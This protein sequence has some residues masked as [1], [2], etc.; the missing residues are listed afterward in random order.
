MNGYLT[1]QEGSRGLGGWYEA[2]M[3]L[4]LSFFLEFAAMM[5]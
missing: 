1:L 5:L 3:G 4:G 2:E